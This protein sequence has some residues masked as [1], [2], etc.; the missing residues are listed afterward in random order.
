M[1]GFLIVE[2]I[3]GVERL[4]CLWLGG[5][6]A[7]FLDEKIYVLGDSVTNKSSSYFEVFD[8]KTQS[9]RALQLPDNDLYDY[10]KCN[11]VE[12]KLYVVSKQKD[13]MYDPKEGTWKVAR[14][15]S[16]FEYVTSWCVIENVIYCYTSFGY[17]SGCREWK[18]I[19]GLEEL[20]KHP[21]RCIMIGDVLTMVN[22]SGKL[23]VVWEIFLYRQKEY[24]FAQVTLETR[25]NGSEVWGMVECVDVMFPAAL[26]TFVYI[27]C[28]TVSV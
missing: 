13:Y 25:G 26:N 16:I 12:G 10:N 3:L 1:F 17:D 28:F 27:D 24:L 6:C 11:V 7:V 19:K 23:L 4:T 20:Y 8:L 14:E 15:E 2:I 18:L 22:H 9:W 21:P 5:M